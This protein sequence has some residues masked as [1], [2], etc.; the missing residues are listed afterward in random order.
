[1]PEPVD[2]LQILHHATTAC[3]GV[4]WRTAGRPVWFVWLGVGKYEMFI[5]SATLVYG[6]LALILYLKKTTVFRLLIA[7]AFLTLAFFLREVL[8]V[9]FAV[10]RDAFNILHQHP[11]SPSWI[12]GKSKLG[13]LLLGK[14]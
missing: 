14:S 4:I 3:L 11:T 5:A 13:I 9:H 10:H 8:R 2:F 6:V 12:C 7:V 1:M